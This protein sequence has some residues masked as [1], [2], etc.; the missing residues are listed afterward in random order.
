MFPGLP[1]KLRPRPSATLS[2]GSTA[3]LAPLP[4]L[5]HSRGTHSLTHSV[6]I[7]SPLPLTPIQPTSLSPLAR[8]SLTRAPPFPPP[9]SRSLGE[10]GEEALV[11]LV[12]RPILPNSSAP[13]PSRHGNAE[14]ARGRFWRI[15]HSS[16]N[17]DD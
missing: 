13:I 3:S 10:F 7:P 17:R 12:D 4:P 15:Y 8:H 1:F 16:V 11:G 5:T 6:T 9:R 2:Q 14:V